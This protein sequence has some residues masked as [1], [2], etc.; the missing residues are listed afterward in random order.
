ME[1]ILE[2][3]KIKDFL[4]LI[5]SFPKSIDT[6]LLEEDKNK[7]LMTLHQKE[8]MEVCGISKEKIANCDNILEKL[9][10]IV[11]ELLSAN[12]NLNDSFKKYLEIE[13]E[14]EGSFS[15]NQYIYAKQRAL[16]VK[17]LYYHKIKNFDKAFVFTLECVALVEYLLKQGMYTL[18][19]R[20]FEQNKNISRIYFKNNQLE[21]GNKTAKSLM[22]YLFNGEQKEG[23]F[24][25]I[26]KDNL[27]WS[28]NPEIREFFAHEA[29]TSVTENMV[30]SNLNNHLDFFSNE[31]YIDLNFE[32][33]NPDRQIIHNWISINRHLKNLNYEEYF[34]SLTCFFQQSYNKF[35]D[36]LKI[37]LLI[38][39]TKLINKLNFEN[40]EFITEKINVFFNHKII[41]N[42][43][44]CTVW[45]SKQSLYNQVGFLL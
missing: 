6:P 5:P 11:N 22:C 13:Q 3:E 45:I 29:F 42:R 4:Y 20:Y 41:S 16:S 12:E 37:S 30:R 28:K 1:T 34:D 19:T 2:H 33:S 21:L 31:W 17:A 26:Y 18:N 25:N 38:D 8:L 44:L 9:V 23:L 24:G 39:L 40:K 27:Y 43:N 10:K 7:L 35:Y 14:I 36:I 32:I 15:G